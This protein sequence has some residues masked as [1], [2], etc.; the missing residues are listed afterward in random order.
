MKKSDI[1]KKNISI[2]FALLLVCFIC[3]DE[4]LFAYECKNIYVESS[5]SEKGLEVKISAQKPIE[6][7][8]K[9]FILK[10]DNP[11][12]LIVDISGCWKNQGKSLINVENEIVEKIRIGEHPAWKVV[13]ENSEVIEEHSPCLRVVLDL[14]TQEHPP[15]Y[16]IK[17]S[18][19]GN[20]II[21]MISMEKSRSG[22][23]NISQ[24]KVISS[25]DI[26]DSGI[27]LLRLKHYEEALDRF[28][29]VADYSKSEK[30]IKEIEKFLRPYS[31]IAKLSCGYDDY[32]QLT[33]L[34]STIYKK[35]ADYV[36]AL[37]AAG[38]Y[39]FIKESDTKLGI[40]YSHYQTWHSNLHEYDLT[41]S[42]FDIYFKSK[43]KDIIFGF[44]Y[45][46]SYYWV[47]SESY[48]MYHLFNFSLGFKFAKNINSEISY[49]YYA[50]NYLKDNNRDG[51]VNEIFTDIAY[52]IGD[53]KGSVFGGL[54]LEDNSSFH[55]DYS[56]TKLKTKIGFSFKLPWEMEFALTGELSEKKYDDVNSLFNIQRE[57]TELLTSIFL[58]R[59]FFYDWL[60]LMLEFDYTI[61]NSNIDIFDYERRA[62]SLSL[63]AR[64]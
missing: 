53:N 63:T 57:D 33:P 9:S 41:G 20:I 29:L 51:H 37:Y 39:N 13:L 47:N 23:I 61:S 24:L 45:L 28:K 5:I 7:E 64:Y 10:D 44:N 42:V 1:L 50:N 62:A 58:S 3:R 36:A 40:G 30:I 32:V 14:K 19:E 48:L 60:S 38:K 46:P 21:S 22:K 54:G 15:F 16:R 49:S 59:T 34:D 18:T 8:Y 11:S 25:E 12:K 35:K 2:I 56:Y 4:Q 26:Y 6:E 55:P 43:Y 52:D 31:L 27:S 17:K